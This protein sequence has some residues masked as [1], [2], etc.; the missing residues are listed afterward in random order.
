MKIQDSKLKAISRHSFMLANDIVSIILTLL[1]LIL[2][3]HFCYPT[4]R[5]CSP[6]VENLSKFGPWLF[7]FAV[8]LLVRSYQAVGMLKTAMRKGSLAL[9]ERRPGS[10]P[11]LL[12]PSAEDARPARAKYLARG[13]RTPFSIDTLTSSSCSCFLHVRRPDSGCQ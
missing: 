2:V 9:S 6:F 4:L 7:P 5:A 13:W 1:P 8:H 10:K 3:L 11:Q 12:K